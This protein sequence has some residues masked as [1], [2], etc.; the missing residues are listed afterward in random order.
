MW[1]LRKKDSELRSDGRDVPG[2]VFR[3]PPLPKTAYELCD[4]PTY[5]AFLFHLWNKYAILPIRIHFVAGSESKL[6]D[7]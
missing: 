6:T 3:H 7:L 4:E 2:R 1:A 5:I